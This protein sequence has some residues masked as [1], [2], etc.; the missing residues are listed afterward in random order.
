MLNRP[1]LAKRIGKRPMNL[2]AATVDL[3][4]LGADV[5]AVTIFEG[6]ELSSGAEAV[7]AATSGLIKRVLRSG[8]ITGKAGETLLIH[9]PNQTN[10]RVLLV[11]AGKRGGIKTGDYTRIARRLLQ[12]LTS[13]LCVRRSST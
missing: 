2:T 6:K 4:K 13:S 1:Y 5:T 8:D 9:V 11:G 12:S 7:D 10:T 3:G